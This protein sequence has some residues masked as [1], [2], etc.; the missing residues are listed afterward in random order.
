MKKV[1]LILAILCALS[2]N[3]RAEDLGLCRAA[4]TGDII[5]VQCS[6]AGAMNVNTV[7]SVTD[8]HMQIWDGATS[9]DVLDGTSHD[10]LYTALTDGTDVAAIDASG[11]LSITGSITSV[12]TRLTTFEYDN[13]NILT[14]ATAT[15]AASADSYTVSV[16]NGG[17]GSIFII[18]CDDATCTG[19]TAPAANVG[20]EI[21]PGVGKTWE[22]LTVRAVAVYNEGAAATDVSVEWRR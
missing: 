21:P 11:A 2:V 17:A 4:G 5:P 18:L 14:T 12:P 16:Y 6:T 10:G 22:S 3:A 13:S 19:E 7:L 9:T 15:I 8:G 20:L 1:I